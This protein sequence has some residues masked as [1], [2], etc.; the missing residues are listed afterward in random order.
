MANLIWQLATKPEARDTRGRGVAPSPRRTRQERRH[1]VAAR[2]GGHRHRRQ[3]RDRQGDRA[4][5]GQGR[6]ATSSSTTLCIR[7]RPKRW[8]EQIAALGDTA[9][10]VEADVSKVAD[11]QALIDTAV[12]KF[13][14]LDIMVNNAGV[15]TR[16]S[17]LDT[18]EDAVRPSAGDQPQERVLRHADRR[19]ADD[20]SR[21]AA[22]GSSTSL[23]CTRTGR[24]RA[25]PP[26]A[27]PRAACGC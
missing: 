11:L 21:A 20:R 23:R 10:G 27:C 26:T 12:A 2:Q 24:C 4:R 6:S 3:Q 7:R 18:T 1:H 14:R 17:V 15:E 19:Q 25:T 13:G 8:S 22:D 9:I 5:A 16:T